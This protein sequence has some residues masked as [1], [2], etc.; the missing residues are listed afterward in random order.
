MHPIINSLIAASRTAA[1]FLP[2][3]FFELEMLQSTSRGTGEFCL[4]SY[5]R[6][7]TIL[8]EELYKHSKFL[9]FSDEEFEI[10]TN[11]NVVLLISPLDSID[12][13][14]RALPF[15]GI[16]ITYLKKVNQIL[17]PVYCIV[18]FPIFNEIYYAE[19]GGGVWIEKIAET[20]LNKLKRLRVSGC[21]D[22]EKAL[23]V[24]HDIN[25]NSRFLK[26]TRVFGSPCY[27][28]ALFASGKID[29]V[30][31]VSL[32]SII[33]PAFEL[34]VRESGGFIVE[35]NDKF[36]ATNQSFVEKLDDIT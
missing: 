30:S 31:L 13:L 28:I 3:D 26:N 4:K 11:A 18:N 24:S 35:N 14:S 5:T 29:I 16:T 12:N 27:E 20:H 32:D 22:I 33:K 10:P 36:I 7:K 34:I 1:K 17:V 21:S 19:K 8:K 9:F 25:K 2:R 6:I 15:F 23:I